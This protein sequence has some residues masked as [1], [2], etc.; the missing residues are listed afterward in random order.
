MLIDMATDVTGKR[1]SRTTLNC[2][3]HA[4]L[5]QRIRKHHCAVKIDKCGLVSAPVGVMTLG[6]GNLLIDDMDL[7]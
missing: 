1:A 3:Q 7:V 6:A 2:R 5:S 4:Q